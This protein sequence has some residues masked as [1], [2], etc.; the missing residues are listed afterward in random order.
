VGRLSPQLWYPE[1]AGMSAAGCFVVFPRGKSGG[2]AEGDSATA[3]AVI[4]EGG[5]ATATKIV[6]GHA[7][8]PYLAGLLYHREGQVFEEVVRS[9]YW[10]KLS[11]VS[12]ST[13]QLSVT[14]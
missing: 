10:N 4:V 7:G 1:D 5:R 11:L 9:R 8:A 3:A 2:V 14:L 12:A 13:S 6:Q